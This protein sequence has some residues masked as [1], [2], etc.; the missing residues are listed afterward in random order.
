VVDSYECGNNL[1]GSIKVGGNLDYPNDYQLLK[2]DS[3]AR[4]LI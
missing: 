4:N 3:A 2:K 1:R